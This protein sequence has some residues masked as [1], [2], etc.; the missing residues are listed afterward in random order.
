MNKIVGIV[1][2]VILIAAMFMVK[3][4]AP[5]PSVSEI[6]P[7][8]ISTI[9]AD[10][11]P[12][13]SDIDRLR[14]TGKTY[15][16]PQGLY[17]FIYPDNYN[18]DT[19]DPVHI[20]IYKRGE[21]QRPQSELSDGVLIV[22]EA[23]DLK[24]QSLER[25]VDSTIKQLTADDTSTISH[26]KSVTTVNTYSGYTF[27]IQGLGDSTHIV[28]QKD[29]QSSQ[30]LDITYQVNDPVQKN[31]QQEVISILSSLQLNK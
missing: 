16:D 8:P 31:Y 25:W 26:A 12:A 28:I 4:P 17:T 1:L 30:A 24:N 6:T 23:I 20:R 10:S 21:M 14:T 13:S 11:I 15:T 2:V 22:F 29:P 5:Q 27:G 3:K 7:S 18:L 9:P 19:T